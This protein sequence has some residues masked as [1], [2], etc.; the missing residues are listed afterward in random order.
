MTLL[1]GYSRQGKKKARHADMTGQCA[2]PA[3][4]ESGRQT[5]DEFAGLGNAARFRNTLEVSELLGA[6]D[7][8]AAGMNQVQMADLIGGGGR[9]A[10]D[11]TF[12]ATQATNPA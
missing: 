4:V 6:K 5:G 12:T 2:F 10:H 7:L 8:N 3:W 11:E 1:S 9:V